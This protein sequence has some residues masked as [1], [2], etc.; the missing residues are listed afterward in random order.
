MKVD[1]SLIFATASK[2]RA[3]QANSVCIL[4]S[5]IYETDKSN[6]S[7]GFTCGTMSRYDLSTLPF[8]MHNRQ[9]T[10]TS[11]G[12]VVVES[13][14][15][16]KFLEVANSMIASK[17]K[18]I[19]SRIPKNTQL[20][21]VW[22][23]KIG[24]NIYKI[25]CGRQSITRLTAVSNM[26]QANNISDFE[27]FAIKSGAVYKTIYQ[28]Q[29]IETE[30]VIKETLKDDVPIIY[31]DETKNRAIKIYSSMFHDKSFTDEF[32]RTTYKIMYVNEVFT[33]QKLTEQ[34]YKFVNSGRDLPLLSLLGIQ[35]LDISPYTH[36]IG[37]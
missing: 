25:D 20:L 34:G 30:Q 19:I 13:N 18:D 28:N 17:K 35:L 22:V 6:Y 8:V 14:E 36:G 31:V 27:A 23:S 10:T 5:V 11:K 1:T 37:E 16:L 4:S 33:V 3:L 21:L 9:S 7:N 32:G 2:M 29:F 24:L 26:L 12:I 15:L